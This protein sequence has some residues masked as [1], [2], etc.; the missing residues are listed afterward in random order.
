MFARAN[1]TFRLMTEC[2]AMIASSSGVGAGPLMLDLGRS[3]RA[4]LRKKAMDVSKTRK[5]KEDDL[6]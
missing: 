6:W 4:I 3:R 5:K 1:W 2:R